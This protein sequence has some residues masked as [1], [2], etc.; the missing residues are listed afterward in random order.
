[1]SDLNEKAVLFFDEMQEIDLL[2]EGKQI[3]GAIREFAQQAKN[4]V[5]IFSGSNRRLLHH[6]FDDNSMPLY[7]LCE[8]IKLEKISAASYKAYISE[9]AINIAGTAPSE[10]VLNAILSISE[11][12]PQTSL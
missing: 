5:F 2:T 12:H 7:E 1:M 10:T 4:V 3:Q 9:A 11:R 8:R 6:M